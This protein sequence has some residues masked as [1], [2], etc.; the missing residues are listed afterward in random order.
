MC[1][2]PKANSPHLIHVYP[3]TTL[4]PIS[5]TCVCTCVW[6]NLMMIVY[7]HGMVFS[8]HACGQS[9]IMSHSFAVCACV[10]RSEKSDAIQCHG[11]NSGF[12]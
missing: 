1:S 6:G 12:H 9:V 5:S 3:I 11:S 10:C 8:V 2:T 4:Y 7:S